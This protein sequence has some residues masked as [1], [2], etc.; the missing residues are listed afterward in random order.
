M[1][2]ISAAKRFFMIPLDGGWPVS[3]ILDGS[4][5]LFDKQAPERNTPDSKIEEYRKLLEKGQA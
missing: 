5:Y 3:E 2:K 1:I 4:A